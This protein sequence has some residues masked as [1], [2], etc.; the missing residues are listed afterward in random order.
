MTNEE[1]KGK[2]DNMSYI[3]MLSYWRFEPTGSP[4]FQG[5]IGDY[6]TK[7]MAEKR[8]EVGPN[9]HTATSKFLGW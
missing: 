3:T 5:E 1:M 6:F 2:I 4:W 8:K 7:K 9:V